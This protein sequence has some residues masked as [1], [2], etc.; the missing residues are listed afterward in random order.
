MFCLL[1]T[2][3]GCNIKNNVENIFT[4]PPIETNKLI[5]NLSSFKKYKL[6]S[7]I[8][9]YPELQKI[10][11]ER[12]IVV[13]PKMPGFKLQNPDIDAFNSG[14]SSYPL[15]LY[16]IKLQDNQSQPDM[17]EDVPVYDLQFY[18]YKGRI[19]SICFD[20]NYDNGD[21]YII[22]E[23]LEKK[24]GKH[25]IYDGSVYYWKNNQVL[26]KLVWPHIDPMDNKSNEMRNVSV[27]YTSR[28]I[29]SLY[30]VDVENYL[31]NLDQKR[32]REI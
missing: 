6:G 21:G 17:I 9:L 3:L 14:N 18:G 2:I 31:N 15:T 27:K 32:I 25:T 1:N 23:T 30:Q 10:E 16:N 20:I 22:S 11:L 26:L 24:Y 19:H 4:Q 13:D 7:D 8:K 5:N 28:E 12:Y 29:D